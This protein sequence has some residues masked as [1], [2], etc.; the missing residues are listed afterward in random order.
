MPPVFLTEAVPR[1]GTLEQLSP[2]VG[3]VVANNPSKFTYHG[4]GTY[5][6]GHPNG[7]EL[8]VIDP[9]PSNQKHLEAL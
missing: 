3:R 5:L 8:A 1:Y 4:T 2:M 7:K 6:V 9:G